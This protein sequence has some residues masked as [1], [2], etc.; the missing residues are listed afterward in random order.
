MVRAVQRGISFVFHKRKK[1]KRQK[2]KAK[3]LW[4]IASKGYRFPY[5]KEQN[6]VFL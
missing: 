1:S 2:I 6:A 5:C 4:H 3:Q